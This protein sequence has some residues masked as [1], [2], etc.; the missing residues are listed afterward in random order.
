MPSLAVYLVA[1]YARR[2]IKRMEA[3]AEAKR[4]KNEE[5]EKQKQLEA[6]STK[7]DADSKLATVLVRLDALEGVVKEIADDKMRSFA[8]DLSAKKEALKKGETSSA[9]EASASES[10]TSHSSIVSVKSTD[11]KGATKCSVKRDTAG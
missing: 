2:E 11:I 1:Q 9:D 8:L 10:N 6:D 3:E 7:E 4:K 5:L